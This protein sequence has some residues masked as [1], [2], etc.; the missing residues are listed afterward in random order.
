[1]AEFPEYRKILLATDGSEQAGLAARH[2]VALARQAGATITA[3]YVVDAH[4][5]FG[6]GIHRDDALRELREDGERALA[7]VV[8]LA[9]GAGLDAE[10][11]L[12]EG[13]PGEEIVRVSER[14]G[15]DLIVLG[16]DGQGAMEDILLGSV[17]QYVVHHAHVPV[18][19]VR[20]PNR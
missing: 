13:R 17:S 4:L 8:E 5:A 10:P 9:R 1:M 2:A 12:C 19:V 3:L 6:L 18:C 20:P 7:A 16:S 15:A 14:G 11:E